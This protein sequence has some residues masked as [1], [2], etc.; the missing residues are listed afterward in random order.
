MPPRIRSF[1]S[2]PPYLR[3][4]KAKGPTPEAPKVFREFVETLQRLDASAQERPGK[5]L[6]TPRT[7]RKRRYAGNGYAR[8]QSRRTR[9]RPQ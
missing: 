5:L 7:A 2:R 6:L 4:A 9:R 8:L 3:E 1:F